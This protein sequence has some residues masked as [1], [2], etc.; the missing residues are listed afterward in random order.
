MMD[1]TGSTYMIDRVPYT[2]SADVL[3]LLRLVAAT[4]G[5]AFALTGSPLMPSE[6]PLGDVLPGW[7]GSRAVGESAGTFEHILAHRGPHAR[8]RVERW[9]NRTLRAVNVDG[10]VATFADDRSLDALLF[11][12]PETFVTCEVGYVF[13][14]PPVLPDTDMD[15]LREAGSDLSA[16]EWSR[17]LTASHGEVVRALAWLDM[18]RRLRS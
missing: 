16:T 4:T 2:A 13:A 17:R 1:V 10:A 18:E 14:R 12:L 3:N 9:G 15:V 7:R 8:V 11:A 5:R 6:R